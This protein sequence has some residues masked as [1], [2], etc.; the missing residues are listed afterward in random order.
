MNERLNAALVTVGIFR[1]QQNTVLLNSYYLYKM[2]CSMII[3]DNAHISNS[4]ELVLLTM[5]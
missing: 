1:I 5:F 3:T 4:I 2:C